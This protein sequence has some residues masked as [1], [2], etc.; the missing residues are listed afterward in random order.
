MRIKT[1][2]KILAVAV[3]I[4]LGIVALALAGAH[5]YLKTDHAQNL[6]LEGVNGVIPGKIAWGGL[7]ADLLIGRLA[8]DQLAIDGPEGDT[9][10][11]ADR[12]MVDIGLTGL[13]NRQLI[14]Q[15]AGLDK[16]DIDLATN[17]AGELN[18]VRAFVPPGPEKPEPEDEGGGLPFGIWVR[19][20]EI[21]KG[22]FAFRMAPKTPDTNGQHAVLKQIDLLVE[23][24]DLAERAGRAKLTIGGGSIDMAGVRTALERFHVETG[25]KDGR[26]KPVVVDIKTDG[27]DA[28]L[29]GTVAR[30]FD[31]PRL[32]VTLEA[33]AELAD[34]REM[35]GLDA[36]ISGALDLALTAKGPLDNPD[37]TLSAGYG[38]GRLA[39]IPVAG[40]DLDS[41]MKDR[42]IEIDPLSA[43]IFNGEVNLAGTVDL[44]DAFA[45]GLAAAPTDI[46]AIAYDLDLGGA[47]IDLAALPWTG[48]LLAGKTRSRISITGRGVL[49]KTLKADMTADITARQLA[50]GDIFSPANIEL[51]A[52]AQMADGNV[53]VAPLDVSTGQSRIRVQGDYRIFDNA[54]DAVLNL[55]SPNLA[56]ILAPLNIPVKTGKTALSADVSGP[57][58]TPA[59]E[60]TINAASL[61]Y[62]SIEV[63]DIDIAAHLSPAGR[64]AIK[65]LHLANRGSKIDISGHIDLFDNGFHRFNGA[66]PADLAATLKSVEAGDFMESLPLAGT[67]NGRLRLSEK[68]MAPKAALF[69]EGR[70]LAYEQTRIGG[71]AADLNLEDGTV[72]VSKLAIEN[73]QSKANITGTADLLAADSL[74]VADSPGVDL[75]IDNT[76]IRLADFTDAADGR[77]NLQGTVKGP[78][79]DPTADLQIDGQGLSAGQTAIG[80]IAA[81]LGF[82]EGRL[83]FEPLRVVNGDSEIRVSG[84]VGVLSP[85]TLSPRPDP[86]MDL[87]VAAEAIYLKDFVEK[88]SGRLTIDG[89]V[90]GSLFDL[91]GRIDI[92]GE[93]LDLGVQKIERIDIE[94]RLSGQKIFF[95]PATV[96]L[97]PEEAIRAEG[98]V[99][100][101]QQYDLELSSD[102]IGLHR[103]GVLKNTALADGRATL[104]FAGAGR[105]AD[106]GLSGRIRIEDLAIDGPKAP[107][108]FDI[109]LALKNQLARINGHFGFDVNARYHLD[110]QTF[111]VNADFDETPLSPYFQL[112]GLPEL[113]GRITGAVYS[114]GNL[115]AIDQA[116]ARIDLRRLT[117]SRN[118]TELLDARELKAAYD[119]GRFVIP[120]NRIDLLGDGRLTIAG[121]GRINGDM[122]ISA[123]GRIP[124]RAVTLFVPMLQEP[125]GRIDLSAALSGRMQNPRVEADVDLSNIG[126]TIAE[127]G[128]KLHRINGRIRLADEAVRIE[129]LSGRLDT[130]RFS[131]NGTIGLKDFAPGP[132]DLKLTART[133]PIQVP[134]M[135][136][137]LINADLAFKGTPDKSALSGDVTI[138]DGLYYK[139]IELNLLEQVGGIGQRR[140]ETEPDAAETVTYDAPY[141]R[142]LTFD[143]NL[144]YRNAFLVENNLALLSLKPE[145]R[146]YGTLARPLVSGRA[147]VSD[148]TVTYRDTE[149]EVQKGVVDFINPY[150]IEPTLALEAVTDVRQWTIT[151]AVSG[152]P[153]N[154]NFQFR[155]NPP[156]E[157]ADIV[158][159]LVTGKTT[160]ELGRGTG[161]TTSPE[162]MLANVLAGR[163]ASNVKSTTG[164]DIFEVGYEEGDTPESDDNIRVTV[165]KELSRRLTVKYGVEQQSGET[166]Q[167]TTTIYKLLEN[168]AVS[169]S[170]ASDGAFGGELRYRMEFR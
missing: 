107:E 22:D 17:R 139:D 6:I 46:D 94:T 123:D 34:I 167:K 105:F 90:G 110:K 86:A 13:L 135:L 134:D 25:L 154:L 95:S 143:V 128:Q 73:G 63:G 150:R 145:L 141:I 47:P 125:A 10:I 101:K 80:D 127:I 35:F 89:Q 20:L 115:S 38:G 66:M 166:V 54:V 153:N 8:V 165:G 5:V 96:A 84:T 100:L 68:I 26:L 106:P 3:G 41:R 40:I 111:N 4:M 102:A 18:I 24:A 75:K 97:A 50:V 87:A 162:E 77:V 137:V 52:A 33:S 29:T 103:V 58:L 120:E 164:L 71:L 121:G 78:V 138:L 74:A 32:D 133:L 76:S 161:S 81:G 62:D 98:W 158:S 7:D 55:D 61:A 169:A 37:A 16:P 132:A 131:A 113:A 148:G 108:A 151:L 9:I 142:Q 56:Q 117:L 42:K 163:L 160:G 67:F 31:K 43:R 144:G 99:S 122:E 72:A 12:V 147:E 27:P 88:L 48:D 168:V 79:N 126:M 64:L 28:K 157:D 21:N 119:Q 124:M 109:H 82:A 65:G 136:E 155:S 149:F 116:K 53:H 70:D 69:L 39:G 92:G 93:K 156:E 146:L 23:D 15:A 112:A 44:A 118:Q 11:A 83:R 57:V 30:V 36:D 91:D 129:N 2:L 14:I 60:A 152:P 45:E 51:A 19:V 114:E 159:L 104:D 49:P 130:G 140:R 170:Q 1:F 85:G 59:I